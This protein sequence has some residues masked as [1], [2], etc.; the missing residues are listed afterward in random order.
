MARRAL[1]DTDKPVT[2]GLNNP[3]F[4][5]AIHVTALK[6]ADKQKKGIYS[7]TKRQGLCCRQRS[8]GQ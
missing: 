1:N 6:P 3:A 7:A 5:W 8:N 4:C 2:T